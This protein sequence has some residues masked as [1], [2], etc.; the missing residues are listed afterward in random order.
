MSFSFSFSLILKFLIS[1]ILS[2]ISF[3]GIIKFIAFVLPA[4][5]KTISLL[6][7]LSEVLIESLDAFFNFS[8][9]SYLLILNEEFGSLNVSKNII[10]PSDENVNEYEE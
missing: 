7:Y 1:V 5:E 8:R 6:P 9:N 4:K 10:F 3:S 2:L